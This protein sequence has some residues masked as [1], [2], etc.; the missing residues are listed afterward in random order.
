MNIRSLMSLTLVLLGSS[1]RAEII[2]LDR[3]EAVVCGPEGTDVITTTDIALPGI[4]GRIHALDD[5]IL[6]RKM[7]QDALRFKVVDADAVD[8]QLKM[9]MRE[10]NLTKEGLEDI[11]KVGGY[12]Y[13]EGIE[14]FEVMTAVNQIN[15]F[16]MSSGLILS[17]REIKEYYDKYPMINPARYSIQR[18]SLP[19]AEG[20]L[21]ELQAT[22]AR[23]ESQISWGEPFW[24][25]ESDI[26]EDKSFI[27]TLRPNQIH[28]EKEGGEVVVTRLVEKQEAQKVPLEQRRSDIEQLIYREKSKKLF[29]EYKKELDDMTAVI[30]F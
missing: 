4:D 22:I 10:N 7:Y 9:I 25:D 24:L 3:I 6:E 29:D 20:S 18:G 19:L 26:A 8:R 21:D 13:A 11:F 5:R 27:T 30:R 2:M 15:N 14:Q 16:R 17:E 23:Y 12:T 28:V 1:M